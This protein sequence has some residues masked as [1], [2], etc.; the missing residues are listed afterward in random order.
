MQFT[1][2]RIHHYLHEASRLALRTVLRRQRAAGGVNLHGA[3]GLGMD[4]GCCSM[5]G[6]ASRHLT[7][8]T[9]GYPLLLR[10]PL[11]AHD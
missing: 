2:D 4:W 9:A 11:Q 7:A 3:P 1:L 5:P 8:R 10:D 6:G